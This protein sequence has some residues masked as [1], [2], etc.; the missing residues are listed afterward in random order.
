MDL[1]LR[2]KAVLI[3]GATG[4]IGAATARRLAAEGAHVALLARGKAE[5]TALAAELGGECGEQIGR[6][7]V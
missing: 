2:D 7:H 4:G 3:V 1:G 6:A 5:L